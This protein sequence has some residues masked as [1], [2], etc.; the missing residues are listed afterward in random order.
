MKKKARTSLSEKSSKTSLMQLAGVEE[1][2]DAAEQAL[3]RS[4]Y[5]DESRPVAGGRSDASSRGRATKRSS[6]EQERRSLPTLSS[7]TAGAPLSRWDRKPKPIPAE[8]VKAARKKNL[9]FT[10]GTGVDAK[11]GKHGAAAATSARG[12]GVGGRR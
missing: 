11:G 12:E 7:G 2:V 4:L 6:K 5:W 8:K 1:A 9:A 3:E 10:A